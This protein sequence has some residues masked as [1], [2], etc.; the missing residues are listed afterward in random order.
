MKRLIC[1]K[2]TTKTLGFKQARQSIQ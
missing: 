1:T 2:I